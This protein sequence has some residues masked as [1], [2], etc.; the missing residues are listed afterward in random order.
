VSIIETHSARKPRIAFFYWVV[1]G[2]MLVLTAGLFYRQLLSQEA[3]T[4]RERLQNQRRILIPGPRGE[5][6]DREGRVLVAN[7]PRFSAVLYFSDPGLRREIRETALKLYRDVRD[8]KAQRPEKGYTNEA[9][10]RVVKKYTDLVGRIL[11]RPVEVDR[12]RVERHFAR[13]PILPYH[14]IEE[15]SPTDFALLT[16]QLPVTSPVQI[17][18]STAR[19]YPYGNAAA[20]ALGYVS[21]TLDFPR[22]SMPGDDLMTFLNKGSVGRNGLELQFDELL[23]GKTGSEIWIVD[24]SGFQVELVKNDPPVQG[25]PLYTSLDIDLQM[26]G[27]QAF[28]DREGALVLLDARTGEV[29]AIVSR[30]DYDLNDLTP[31]ITRDT[32]ADIEDRGAWENR[33]T[34]G[35][36]PPGSPFKLITAMAA[37]RAGAITPETEIEC[38]GAIYVG[39]KRFV[40]HRRS[41]HGKM[42]LADAIRVSCNVY[43]YEAALA[44]GVERI[45]EEARRFGLNEPTGIELPHEITKMIVPDPQWKRATEGYG[46]VKGDTANMAI[47][48]GYLVVTPLQMAAFTA[49]LARN[50]TRTRPTILRRDNGMPVAVANNRSIGLPP[51][52]RQ[53]I[54]DGMEQAVQYGTAKYAA[55]PGIRLAGKTGTAQKRTPL[56][57]LELAWFVGFGPIEDPQVAI[58]VVVVGE[59]PDEA[60]AGG[61]V[62]API[63]RKV[64]DVYFQKHPP[65]S[66]HKPKVAGF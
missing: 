22:E 29:L 3:F 31:I 28:G 19:F 9:R 26:I 48:Q 21:S 45:A 42:R 49:S 30:P 34:R 41:G 63:A 65:H 35:L 50:E 58:A 25:H 51:R 59:Q 24:P 33:A 2:I 5:I 14:I 13:R 38:R 10:F 1:A 15:L 17:Y 23:Q 66:A 55:I 53:A 4:E 40:C 6:F 12:R 64:L 39:R 52:D 62:A 20:H 54:I 61:A 11:G 44:T 7:R 37:L 47:G 16:E 43:F 60:N 46:W 56:G 18:A 8:G 36:Y 32:F 27:E 57:T